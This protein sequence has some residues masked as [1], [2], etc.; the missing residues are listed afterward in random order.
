MAEG[1]PAVDPDQP[2]AFGGR[3]VAGGAAERFDHVQDHR[4]G[5]RRVGRRH[6]Q[7]PLGGAGKLHDLVA[8]GLLHAAGHRQRADLPGRIG[9]VGV[10][11]REPGRPEFDERQRIAAGLR[12]HPG[13]YPFGELRCVTVEQPGGVGRGE[14]GQVHD[15]DARQHERRRRL[16]YGEQHRDRVGHEA[17][18]GEQQRLRG[19]LVEPLQV[20]EQAQQ[21][22]VLGQLGEQR[23]RA[24]GDQEPVGVASSARPKARRSA[25]A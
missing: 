14:A 18:G 16:P 7:R 15:L 13:P 20:I 12:D 8:V 17:A 3:Q 6:Q 4:E 5:R 10:A 23:Q 11:G 19:A 21:W 2:V 9:L 24:G 1:D 22:G 25:L